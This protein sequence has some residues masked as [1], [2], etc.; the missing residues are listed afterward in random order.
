MSPGD[1]VEVRVLKM[2]GE[3]SAIVDLKGNRV[4][5]DFNAPPPDT[6]RFIL[7]LLA[8]K[9][10]R[11]TFALKNGGSD[12]S[13]IRNFIPVQ[14]GDISAA[15]SREIMRSLQSGLPGLYSLNVIL[16]G[17]KGESKGRDILPILR[18]LIAKGLPAAEIPYVSAALS[19]CPSDQ[20]GKLG[21]ILGDYDSDSS[22]DD[23]VEEKTGDIPLS[24]LPE[25]GERSFE[26]N[27][28]YDSEHSLKRVDFFIRGNYFSGR[29]ELPNLGIVEFFL[30]VDE[31]PDIMIVCSD[32]AIGVMS[33]G[34]QTL[35][36]AIA[37]GYPGATVWLMP[38]SS[39]RKKVLAF[40]GNLKEKSFD[41]RA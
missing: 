35:S 39:V 20:C 9:N 28:F 41:A 5:L 38:A 16:S 11:L 36:D 22:G 19:G 24:D 32:E 1:T 4:Q 17:G 23:A 3:K 30:H 14:P 10:G 21:E 8:S 26:K 25:P 29:I 33:S 15:V 7:E 27:L 6:G 34:I 37:R 40:I 18:Y 12:F 31:K 13:D 2:I